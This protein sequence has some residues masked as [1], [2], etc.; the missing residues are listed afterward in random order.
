MPGEL[1]PLTHPRRR[2]PSALPAEFAELGRTQKE[3]R[4]AS[5]VAVTLLGA[6]RGHLAWLLE[7]GRYE[8]DLAIRSASSRSATPSS[9]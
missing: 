2:A 8:T 7:S 1:G 6:P 5:K 9:R 3:S 4:D